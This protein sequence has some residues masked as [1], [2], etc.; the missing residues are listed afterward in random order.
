MIP[1]HRLLLVVLAASLARGQ[2]GPS[3]Q[4]HYCITYFGSVQGSVT[5]PQGPVPLRNYNGTAECPLYWEFPV[6]EGATLT[7]CPAGSADAFWTSASD[8]LAIDVAV[9]FRGGVTE[10]LARPLDSLLLQ[11]LL[12]TNG[13]AAGPFTG[14]GRPAVLAKDV[15]QSTA[16]VPTWIINGTQEAEIYSVANQGVY[17][18]CAN[19]TPKQQYQYCGVF[20]DTNSGGGCWSSYHFRFNM[21]N[22]L[23]FSIQFTSDSAIVE[24]SSANNYNFTGQNILASIHFQGTTA[25]PA[26]TDAAFW[27]NSFQTF[28]QYQQQ[29]NSFELVPDQEGLPLFLNHTKTGEWYD[30]SNQT[31]SAR[32]GSGPSIWPPAVVQILLLAIFLHMGASYLV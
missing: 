6:V 13:S 17:F 27:N 23:N 12:V 9:N 10:T 31:Y 18:D 21:S 22:P 5:L 30:T 8:H 3:N 32:S 4:E 1:L 14:G 7:L 28:A 29:A 26:L 16:A 11:N 2:S 24:I 19:L 20:E 25:I 15:A